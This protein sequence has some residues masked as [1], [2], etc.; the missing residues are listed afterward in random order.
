MPPVRLRPGAGLADF[1]AA[2]GL[3]GALRAACLA[4]GLEA[5]FVGACR[6]DLAADLVAGLPVDLL[7]ALAGAGLPDAWVEVF[8]TGLAAGLDA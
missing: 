4:A 2:A 1:L 7:V 3:A 6:V 8:V 5:A